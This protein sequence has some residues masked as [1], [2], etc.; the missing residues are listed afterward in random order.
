MSKDVERSQKIPPPR[1]EA[2]GEQEPSNEQPIPPHDGRPQGPTH[3]ILSPL[4]PTIRRIGPP[5]PYIVGAGEDVDV[6]MGPLW[7]PVRTHFSLFAMYWPL[8]SP[9]RYPARVSLFE[10]YCAVAMH[11]MHKRFFHDHSQTLVIRAQRQAA[12]RK[13]SWSRACCSLSR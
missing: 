1:R 3:R 5:S 12:A 11:I 8:W 13:R 7:L 2:M 10:M 6:G 4:A 9:V